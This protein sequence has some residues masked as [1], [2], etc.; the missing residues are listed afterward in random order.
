MVNALKPARSSHA[1]TVIELLVVIT[2]I[3]ILTALVVACIDIFTRNTKKAKT[4]A[5]LA[6]V[7]VALSLASAEGINIAPVEHPLAGSALVGGSRPQFVRATGGSVSS[8]GE[9]LK[10]DD[11][12]WVAGAAQSQVMLPTDYFQG[13]AGPASCVLPLLYG[14]NRD[15][16][17]IIGPAYDLITNYRRLPSI[18]SGYD[19]SP[20]TSPATLKSPYT[21]SNYPDDRFLVKPTLPTTPVIITPEQRSADIIKLSLATAQTEIAGL[22][23]LFTADDTPP[24]SPSSSTLIMNNRV[25]QPSTGDV[26]NAAWKSGFVLDGGI[27]RR[28]RL[29]GTAVY[30]AWGNEILFSIAANGAVRLESAGPDGVF[31]WL[32]GV[33]RIYQTAANA[34]VAAGD[35]KDGSLDNISPAT[36]E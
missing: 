30:D 29:R 25:R 35:D 20:A 18:G 22:N 21:N 3:A 6:S 17:G 34:T 31:R 9:A 2:I 16:I 11:I 19:V 23:G 27:W 33:D 15:R 26:Q 10:V 7:R 36:R 32:P 13:G 1:F 28:Y 4:N 14:M 8:S 5:I 12:N 24:P